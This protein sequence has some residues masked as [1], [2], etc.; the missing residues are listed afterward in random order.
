MKKF[1]GM[2]YFVAL[3][4]V[5]LAPIIPTENNTV[6]AAAGV[7]Y[8]YK[9]KSCGFHVIGNK[10]IAQRHANAYR[11]SLTTYVYSMIA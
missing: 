8:G 6:E 2:F 9:C 5:L 7:T 11:H 3:S 10:T 1:K 4:L